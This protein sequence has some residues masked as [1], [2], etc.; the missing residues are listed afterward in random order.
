MENDCFLAHLRDLTDA[1]DRSGAPRFTAF[2][3]E[4]EQ[5]LACRVKRAGMA[6]TCFGGWPDAERR[7]LCV[8]PA[9]FD[10]GDEQFPL[11]C[12]SVQYRKQDAL[13]HRDIL[14]SVLAL[15]LK[16]ELV[17]DILLR[18]GEAQLFVCRTAAPV[19]TQELVRIGR[20]GVRVESC[21]FSGGFTR[22]TEPI[23]GTVASLRLDA[24]V[25]LATRQSRTQAAAMIAGQL[26][27]V[28]G[29]PVCSPAAVLCE[30]DVI[31][32]RG[33]GK[34]RLCAVSGLSKKGRLHITLEKFC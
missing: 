29:L 15:G 4:G 26:V 5:A 19:I 16:R 32:V 7:M 1:A 11:V 27:S 6:Q 3:S 21:T 23:D 8:H 24:V 14:G 17:G 31:S 13:T 33:F 30:G 25:H 28:G 12:L 2:L 34:F 10:V 20:T 9:G 18:E 22:K